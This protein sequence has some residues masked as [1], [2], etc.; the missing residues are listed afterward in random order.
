MVKMKKMDGERVVEFVLV[1][2]VCRV[3]AIRDGLSWFLMEEK[4]KK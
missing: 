3:F 4:L 2:C 1:S